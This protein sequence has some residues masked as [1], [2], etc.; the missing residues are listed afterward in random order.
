MDSCNTIRTLI[1]MTLLFVQLFGHSLCY[2]K[3]KSFCNKLACE[4]LY[5]NLCY[6]NS[7]NLFPSTWGVAKLC[8]KE[9][10]NVRQFP[11]DFAL[12]KYNLNWVFFLYNT[13]HIINFE[14]III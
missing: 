10:K 12:F 14:I 4:L 3:K 1:M 2:G 13:F 5:L 8:I 11:V 9:E 7:V 6:W